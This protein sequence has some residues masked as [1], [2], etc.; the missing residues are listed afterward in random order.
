MVI[1]SRFAASRIVVPLGTVT[2]SLSMV[3]VT[4]MK[5][6]FLKKM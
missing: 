6:S 5:L 1:P 3:R 2:D 4:L